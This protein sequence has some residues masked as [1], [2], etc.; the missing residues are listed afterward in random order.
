MRLAQDD[1]RLALARDPALG[2]ARGEALRTLL[3]LH[4]RE[5]AIR[6]LRAG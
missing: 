6:Y 5:A 1:A 2:G 4:E 3:W